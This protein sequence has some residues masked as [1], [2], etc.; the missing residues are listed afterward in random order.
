MSDSHS[1]KC[2]FLIVRVFRRLSHRGVPIK[3]NILGSLQRGNKQSSQQEAVFRTAQGSMSITVAQRLI[4]YGDRTEALPSNH[5]THNTQSHAS[6]RNS[7]A[8]CFISG[9]CIRTPRSSVVYRSMLFTRAVCTDGHASL[10]RS[11]AFRYHGP[12]TYAI[13]PG[14]RHATVLLTCT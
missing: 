1:A 11:S 7:N 9:T 5:Y 12:L 13:L 2:I 4:A 6:M 3:R 14:S 10:E 8:A